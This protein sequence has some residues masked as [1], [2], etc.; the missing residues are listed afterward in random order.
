[1]KRLA[2]ALWLLFLLGPAFLPGEVLSQAQQEAA[3]TGRVANGTAG[4]G[5]TAGL[6]VTLTIF[7]PATAGEPTKRETVADETG[8]FTFEQVPL[9]ADTA[10][11]LATVYANVEYFSDPGSLASADQLADQVLTV[12]ETTSDPSAIRAS[13]VHVVIQA[14]KENRSLLVSELII[15]NNS[16]DRTYV[17]PAADDP[18]KRPETLRFALP[19]DAVDVAIIDGLLPEDLIGTDFGFTD[20]SPWVPGVRQAAFS[21]SLPYRGSDYVFRITLDFPADTVNVLMPKGEANLESG[22]PFTQ[23]ETALQGQPYVRAR[24]ENLEAGAPIQAILT[25]LP[26]G[27]GGSG[28]QSTIFVVLVVAALGVLAVFGYSLYRRRRLA[29]AAVEDASEREKA[30]L[31]LTIAELDRQHEAGEIG[32]AQ[33]R[34]RRAEAKKRLEAIW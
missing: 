20:T 7:G 34:R 17:G 2:L 12:Y 24:A 5:S 19:P 16:G 25:G 30:S 28:V 33:Y 13:M 14:D 4:G 32:D 11:Q 31:L 9:S 23:D 18:Q 15:I 6:P 21:Y 26:R 1:V 22:S 3:V 8:A 27:G 29:A 10:Y